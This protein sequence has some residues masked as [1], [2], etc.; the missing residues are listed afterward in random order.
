MRNDDQTLRTSRMQAAR[1]LGRHTRAEWYAL[2]AKHDGRCVYCA[3]RPQVLTK[4]HIVPV[5]RGGSDAITN[6]VPCCR[7]CN[8]RKH[9]AEGDEL[10]D[11]VRDG[12]PRALQLGGSLA[13]A[14]VIL[15]RQRREALERVDRAI[16][17]YDEV[18]RR[19][20]AVRAEVEAEFT[21]IVLRK[22][23]EGASWREIGEM[24]G[25]SKQRAQ[26]RFGD[27]EKAPAQ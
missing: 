2:I 17:N 23:A 6:I 1:N 11:W 26:K 5:S 22:R 15:E 13:E 9:D 4:D 27:A 16:E 8:S 7:S 18:K 24:F 25:V 14:E 19:A 20:N 21:A 10:D 3:R 12:V